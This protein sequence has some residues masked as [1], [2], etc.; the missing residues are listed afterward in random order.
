MLES[1]IEAP[2]MKAVLAD[3]DKLPEFNM[4]ARKSIRGVARLQ[5]CNTDCAEVCS[6][7][8]DTSL[9]RR[10]GL[11]PA[12]AMKLTMNDPLHGGA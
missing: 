8:R 7:P 9:A 2:Y 12:W 10:M 11:K 5:A 4:S 3:L 1:V 6:A